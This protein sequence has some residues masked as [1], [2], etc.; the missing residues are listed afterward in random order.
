MCALEIIELIVI[1][2]SCVLQPILHT[3]INGMSQ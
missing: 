3:I 1:F 2:S